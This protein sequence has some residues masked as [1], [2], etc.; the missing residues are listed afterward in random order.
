MEW[1]GGDLPRYAGMGWER[2]REGGVFFRCG[3]WVLFVPRF[4]C[5]FSFFSLFPSFFFSFNPPSLPSQNL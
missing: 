3:N 5:G 2:G 1:G 4:F